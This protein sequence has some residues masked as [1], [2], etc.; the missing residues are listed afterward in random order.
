VSALGLTIRAGLHTAEREVHEG[1]LAGIAVNIA[2]RIASQPAADEVL[3]S[4]TVKD[5]VVRSDIPFVERGSREL[6]GVPAEWSL[7]TVENQG[8]P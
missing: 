7:F 1:K 4:S 6:K 2:A 8:E 5:L 3:V